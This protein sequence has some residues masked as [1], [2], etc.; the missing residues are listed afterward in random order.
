M[1]LLKYADGEGFRL[2]EDLK[3]GIPSYAILS[4]RWGP[5]TDEVSYKD[6]VDRVGDAK[7][8]Y[9]KLEFCAK[10]ARRNGLQHFWVDTCCI[11]KSDPIEVQISINS[12]FRWYRD[13]TRCYVYLSDVSVA[14][15]QKPH[16]DPSEAPWMSAFRES[17]WF[18][19]GW[20]LQELLAPASVEFF[21]NN[22]QRLGDKKSLGQQIHEITGIG[23]P[24][25]RSNQLSQFD[26]EE[27][28]R[29]AEKR[30]TKYEED[31][32]YCLLGIFGVFIV[33]NYGKGKDYAIRQL[34]REIDELSERP[35]RP[36]NQPNP[37]I[38]IPFGRDEDFVKRPALLSQISQKCGRPGSRTAIIGLGGVGY[39]DPSGAHKG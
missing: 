12:M 30:E 28:F 4:H 16:G 8:G 10:Q 29:W 17:R 7:V 5:D 32:A 14:H 35:G 18:T 3:A 37:S 6:I 26:V 33:P 19:R 9:K 23:I 1:R 2:T 34:R 27:R 21:S 11:D 20:T 38:I 22:G 39:I 13:A 24:A 25:L 15:E 36:Q 31:W